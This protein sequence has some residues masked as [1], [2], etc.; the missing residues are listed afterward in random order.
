VGARRRFIR[1]PVIVDARRFHGTLAFTPRFDSV[2][3][4]EEYHGRMN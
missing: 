4:V 3:A 1:N 2:G